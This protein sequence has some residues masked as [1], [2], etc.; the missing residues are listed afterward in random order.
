MKHISSNGK[1]FYHAHYANKY[2]INRCQNNI[3]LE[4]QRL[5]V[6]ALIIIHTKQ[7]SSV[8]SDSTRSRTCL[9]SASESF[10]GLINVSETNSF[11][12]KLSSA[13]RHLLNSIDNTVLAMLP[14][15]KIV[16]SPNSSFYWA[17]T[18]SIDQLEIRFK[19]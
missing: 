6:Y 18:Y 16:S 14:Q 3:F 2:P 17:L 11:L 1:L 13:S 5:Y 15:V 9:C 10:S 8:S 19:R 4:K 7:F 12:L